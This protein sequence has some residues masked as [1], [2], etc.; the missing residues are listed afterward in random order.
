MPRNIGGRKPRRAAPVS[1]RLIN[2]S[3]HPEYSATPVITGPPRPASRLT[4]ISALELRYGITVNAIACR[5]QTR[6]TEGLERP[7]G[8]EEVQR[9]NP[10]WVAPIVVWLAS[11][12]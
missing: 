10:R 4:I 11:E 12:E 2:T 8:R 6:M 9:R 5:A 3:P 1:A 7:H